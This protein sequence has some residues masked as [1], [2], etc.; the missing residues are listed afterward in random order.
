MLF[1]YVMDKPNTWEDYLH[2]VEFSYNN[3]QQALLGM[4]PFEAFYGKRC[5]KPVTWD[6]PVNKIVLGPEFLKEME[7]EVA[8]IRLKV[9]QD[10]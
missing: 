6:N 1:M 4:S 3:G 8:N 2:L 9:D 5:K 7:H 10:R